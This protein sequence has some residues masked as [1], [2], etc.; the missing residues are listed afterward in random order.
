MKSELNLRI[1]QLRTDERYFVPGSEQQATTADAFR[2]LD[3]KKTLGYVGRFLP[4]RIDADDAARQQI[5]KCKRIFA[6][7]L[8]VKELRTIRLQQAA[9][10]EG[11]AW[12]Q[13]LTQRC[14]P[15]R[16]CLIRRVPKPA[17]PGIGIVQPGVQQGCAFGG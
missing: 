2:M 11:W 10:A 15:N 7:D 14:R 12:L 8:R 17:Q 16:C 6:T 1:G 9:L 13:Y 4:C 3:Q 5:W